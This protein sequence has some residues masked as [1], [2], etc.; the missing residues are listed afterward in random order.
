MYNFIDENLIKIVYLEI[1]GEVKSLRI[2]N[3]FC[4]F[5]FLKVEV[6]FVKRSVCL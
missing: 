2:N 1:F 6:V 3:R 4:Y 5:L